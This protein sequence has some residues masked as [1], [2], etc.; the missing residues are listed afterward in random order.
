MKWWNDLLNGAGQGHGRLILVVVF[1]FIAHGA[2]PFCREKSHRENLTV[3]PMR[4]FTARLLMNF[5]LNCGEQMGSSARG[6]TP[7]EVQRKDSIRLRREPAYLLE[8]P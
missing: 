8:I 2:P 4:S 7:N 5:F 3:H 1:G 6:R